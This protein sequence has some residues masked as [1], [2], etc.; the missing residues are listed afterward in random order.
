MIA[1]QTSWT[2]RRSGAFTLI[3]LPF[4]KL[5]VVRQRGRVAF[6]LIELLVVIAIIAVLAGILMPSLASARQLARKAVCSSNLRSMQAALSLYLEDNNRAYFP[7]QEMR[8]DGTLWYWGFEPSNSGATE[9]TRPLDLARARLA[10]Y[11][12]NSGKMKICPNVPR[13]ASYFKPKFGLAGY[14]YAINYQMLPDVGGGSVRFDQ[15]TRPSETVAWADS[16]QINTWQAP[17]SP[18]NPMLEDWYYLDNHKTSPADF[19]FRHQ[20]RCNA[21]FADGS[22]RDLAPVSLDARCDGLVGRPEDPV[23]GSQVPPLLKLDK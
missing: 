12:T 14:G 7:Y 17:A 23:T 8:P 11:F 6:T 15:I 1:R 3:E 18:S 16:V 13:E 4:D 22:V 20:K 5:G 19:H 9:G 21:V 2:R 10:P